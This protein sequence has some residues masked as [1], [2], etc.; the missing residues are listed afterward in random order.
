MYTCEAEKDD[1]FDSAE[2]INEEMTNFQNDTLDLIE[3][4]T[5]RISFATITGITQPQT[6]KLKGYIKNDNVIILIETGSTHNFLDIKIARKIKL[7]V[8]PIPDRK[9]MVA[10]EIVFGNVGKFHKVKLQIQDF[11]LESK[12]YTVPL[13]G[14]DVVLGV[15]WLQ[16]LGTNSVNHH[17]YF[18]QFKWHGKSYKLYGFQPPQK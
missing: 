17:E 4:N 11:N 5:Q 6:L 8:Y 7:F 3:D 1:E 15:Q 10:D 12:L 9:V 13:G 16:T 2:S 14:V 18:I